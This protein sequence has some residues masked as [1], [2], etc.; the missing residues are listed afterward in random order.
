M[1]PE[2]SRLMR[3]LPDALRSPRLVP[4]DVQERCT[5]VVVA[6]GDLPPTVIERRDGTWPESDR[7]LVE[8]LLEVLAD[9]R[10]STWRPAATPSWEL[11][12]TLR[13]DGDDHIIRLAA[14]GLVGLPRRDA[15]GM[16]DDRTRAALLGP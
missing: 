16:L 2:L 7:A 13:I 8:D 11:V 12:I 3:E 9:A 1:T 10:I 15:V 4:A 5:A 14:D 6:E